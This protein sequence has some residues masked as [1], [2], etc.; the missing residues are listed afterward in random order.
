MNQTEFKKALLRGQG[1]CVQAVKENPERYRKALL[2]ACQ[3]NIAFDAQCE[4]TKASYLYDMIRCYP[5]ISPFIQAISRDLLAVSPWFYWKTSQ[6]AQLLNFFAQDGD[7]DAQRALWDKYS[8]IYEILRARKRRRTSYFYEADTFDHFCEIIAV[9]RNTTLRIATDI[10]RL[11]LEKPF[12][13]DVGFEWFYSQRAKRCFRAL[14]RNA[15]K[16]SEVKKYLE[17]S[18]HQ[19]QELAERLKNRPKFPPQ[20]PIAFSRWLKRNAD[21]AA[22]I[23]YAREYLAERDPEKRAKALK[24]F[25]R[26]PFPLEPEA[27][28]QDCQSD[29]WQLREAA[30]QALENISH[31]A[32]REFALSRLETDFE[33][34]ISPLVNNCEPADIKLITRLVK[35]FPA[36]A[37]DCHEL[38]GLHLEIVNAIDRGV[39]IPKEMCYH[40]YNT[41]YCACC[42]LSFVEYMEKHRMLT[43]EILQECLFDSNLDIR[44]YAQRTLK[45]RNKKTDLVNK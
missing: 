20:N 41:G 22:R 44:R 8:Q 43:D 11:Y 23:N 26:C 16:S 18:A 21:D 9:D 15:E 29:C 38:H 35:E 13:C 42:R 31:P 33:K 2:W 5:D 30:W 32:V 19:E 12:Y 10:G 17:V 4:G 39:R 24:R 3:R 28:I 27:I 34:A 40:I 14:E 45:R 7:A 1:R 36:E 6:Q 25:C 37:K